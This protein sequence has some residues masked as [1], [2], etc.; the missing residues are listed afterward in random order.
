MSVEGIAAAKV[1]EFAVAATAL[2][3]AA[4][5]GVPLPVCSGISGE[6]SA[7]VVVRWAAASSSAS[8]RGGEVLYAHAVQDERQGGPFGEQEH[9]DGG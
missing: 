8:G 6:E 2:L 1:A 3:R 7:T 9:I 4:V 5:I